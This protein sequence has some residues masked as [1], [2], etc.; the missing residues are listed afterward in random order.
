MCRFSK[1]LLFSFFFC[2]DG[3][4]RLMKRASFSCCNFLCVVLAAAYLKYRRCRLS[5][6][7][8]VW[9]FFSLWHTHTHTRT[10]AHTHTHTHTHTH[11]R[12]RTY[13]HTQKK[14]LIVQFSWFLWSCKKRER[15]VYGGGR[16]EH[17]LQPLDHIWPYVIA[18]L[19]C[20]HPLGP[21]CRE[22]DIQTPEN[23]AK[24][25][26]QKFVY[27]NGTVVTFSCSSGFMLEGS[28]Q[29]KCM[30]NGTWSRS[31]PLCTR[32]KYSKICF[33]FWQWTNYM[34]QCFEERWWGLC[35]YW[36][37]TSHDF[38]TQSS[39]SL[40]LAGW[41][42]KMASIEIWIPWRDAHKPHCSQYLDLK[43]SNQWQ[44]RN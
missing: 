31:P 16:H 42:D 9:H 14:H 39:H 40:D 21:T 43:D 26:N 25:P 32:K 18:L 8:F 11:A 4:D 19:F 44:R 23:G 20:S 30:P 34:K 37:H 2:K 1:L 29:S 6:L 24:S 38:A 35:E 17:Q 12:T 41:Q 36:R 3:S 7:P 33:L 28:N 15:W 13:K 10:H 27:A 5:C 22:A